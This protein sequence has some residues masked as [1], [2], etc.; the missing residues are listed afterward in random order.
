MKNITIAVDDEIYRAA[1]IRAAEQSTSISAMFK[2]FLMRLEESEGAESQFQRLQR[3]EAELR[4][5]MR[6][7]RRSLNPAHNLSREELHARHALH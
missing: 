5:E 2:S 7:Q 1:R 4:T 3:E 6:A